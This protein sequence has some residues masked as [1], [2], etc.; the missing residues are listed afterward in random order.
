MR[1]VEQKLQKWH[2][3][4]SL[5]QSC[6]V[7][8]GR[9]C[10]WEGLRS[11]V[12]E[13]LSVVSLWLSVVSAI[14]CVGKDRS[15][16]DCFARDCAKKITFNENSEV[17]TKKCAPQRSSALSFSSLETFYKRNTYHILHPALQKRR[18]TINRGRNKRMNE[19][20]MFRQITCSSEVRWQ[21]YNFN[22]PKLQKATYERVVVA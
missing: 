16:F 11:V 4:I 18:N 5:W 22:D 19:L 14:F 3:P 13:S 17:R 12:S 21:S 9:D 6:C 2:Q 15:A 8:A 7:E 1:R 20:Q 10:T